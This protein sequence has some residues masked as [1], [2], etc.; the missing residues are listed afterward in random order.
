MDTSAILRRVPAKP[1]GSLASVYEPIEKLARK[2]HADVDKVYDAPVPLKETMPGGSS[3]DADPAFA[4]LLGHTV[5]SGSDMVGSAG[6]LASKGIDYLR[7]R[8]EATEVSGEDVGNVAGPMMLPALRAVPRSIKNMALAG[9]GAE[10]I[11]PSNAEA[12]DN[13]KSG[14]PTSETL[15]KLPG[16][17]VEGSLPSAV[18]NDPT[19]K[20]LLQQIKEQQDIANSPVRPKCQRLRARGR[21]SRRRLCN[22]NSTTAF[23]V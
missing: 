7:G 3:L 8:P 20:M 15:P 10:L 1:R 9:L 16:T 17:S 23:G 6:R 4:R 11:P 14:V 19:V 18:A 5:A 2:G 22:L 21:S 13:K 12:K